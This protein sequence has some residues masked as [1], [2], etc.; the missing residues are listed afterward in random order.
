MFCLL[1]QKNKSV[2]KY[3]GKHIN[4]KIERIV[5]TIWEEHCLECSPPECYKSCEKYRRREDG[6]CIRVTNGI[7]ASNEFNGLYG[8]SAVVE[9]REWSKIEILYR[10]KAVS[11]DEN[12][13][14]EKHISLL[15]NIFKF[16]HYPLFFLKDPW[17]LFHRWELERQKYISFLSRKGTEDANALLGEIVNPG[18]KFNLIVEIKTEDTVVYRKSHSLAT[19]ENLIIDS[20]DSQK[21]NEIKQRKYIYLYPEQFDKKHKLFF[22]TLELVKIK[23]KKSIASKMVKCVVWDLDNTLW[24]GI[25]VDQKEDVQI[26][27]EVIDII[28]ML[29][30]KG[31]VSSICSKNDFEPVMEYLKSQKLDSMFLVPQINW[32]PKSKNIKRIAELL[33]IGV[34][35]IAFFDDSIN[36]RNEVRSNAPMVRVY[37]ILDLFETVKTEPFNPPVSEE[38]KNRKKQY[39]EN[40]QRNKEI[41]KNG[42]DVI[43]FLKNAD[44]NLTINRGNLEN[45]DRYYEIVQRTNQ[46]NVSVRRLNKEQIV[47]YI[48]SPDYEFIEIHLTDKYGDYGIIGVCNISL[49]NF[50][51]ED[52]LFS[53]RAAMK[54]VEEKYKKNSANFKLVEYEVGTLLEFPVW[55]LDISNV[56]NEKLSMISEHTSQLHD[57]NYIKTVEALN[58]YRGGYNGV[59][60][61]EAYCPSD[62]IT[63]GRI[64]FWHLPFSLRNMIY[65]VRDKIKR[66]NINEK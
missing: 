51:V 50:V 26:K 4:D 23:D 58:S 7:S 55:T 13:K 27:S 64:I 29:E 32:E 57:I 28:K 63:V 36:E 56:M 20:I 44:M 65:K 10:E 21:L 45:I 5:P 42:G 49:E 15:D 12:F 66:K 16:T 14:I 60:Y 37:D 62:Y 24:N 59:Q 61:A 18:E 41:Q 2:N 40:I 31:I 22:K 33:N 6:S 54:F 19:G 34:D 46:L 38:T 48:Q 17:S 35:S 30:N 47:S 9:F 11:I 25:F 8:Y 39:I 1:W 53:C 52:M 43:A 3:T